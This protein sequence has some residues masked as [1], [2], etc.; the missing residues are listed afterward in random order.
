MTVSVCACK[1]PNASHLFANVV[2]TLVIAASSAAGAGVVALPWP[3]RVLLAN[4]AT[5]L[6]K[7]I[8]LH[9]PVVSANATYILPAQIVIFFCPRSVSLDF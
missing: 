4:P 6:A 3:P 7:S 2:G 9:D 1:F 5:V 8:S